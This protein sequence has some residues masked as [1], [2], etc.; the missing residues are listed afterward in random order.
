MYILSVYVQ[1]R[2]IHIFGQRA[3]PPWWQ[4]RFTHLQS[5]ECKVEQ[6]NQG[7]ITWSENRMGFVLLIVIPS[8]LSQAFFSHL[9]VAFWFLPFP[10]CSLCSLLWKH[11]GKT[12]GNNQMEGLNMT[13]EKLVWH[14]GC[15]VPENHSATLNIPTSFF[16]HYWCTEDMVEW[17]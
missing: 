8:P 13:H 9:V 11:S 3:S 2:Y 15:Q 12:N 6:K 7:T 16:F 4:E 14:L 1:A 10:F 17:L 5:S